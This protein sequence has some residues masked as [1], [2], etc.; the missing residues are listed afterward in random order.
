M[1]STGTEESTMSITEHEAAIAKAIRGAGLRTLL[2][3]PPAGCTGHC[4]V[5]AVGA[6][7]R[8]QIGGKL[9]GSTGLYPTS[10][11]AAKAVIAHRQIGQT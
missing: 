8:V 9:T 4:Q 6:G 11:E 2:F 3:A 7:Y 1:E 10:R 5:T